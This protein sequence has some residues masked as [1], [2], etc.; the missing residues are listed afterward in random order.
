MAVAGAYDYTPL[1]GGGDIIPGTTAGIFERLGLENPTVP[2]FRLLGSENKGGT[3]VNESMNFAAIPGQSYRLVNNATGKV[4]G[5][6]SS[7]EEIS[8]LVAQSNALSKQLGKKADLSFEQSTGGAYSPIFKDQPNILFD[9]PMK[10]IAAGMLAAT[11]A[12]LLQPGGLGGV[13][14][15]GSD[16]AISN[17]VANAIN[18]AYTG[19]QAGAASALAPI[20]GAGAG[21]F[22][23]GAAGAG[24]LLSE[25]S[26]L[27]PGAL[28]SLPSNLASINA[29]TQASLAGAGLGGAT[30]GLAV[31]AFGNV[32]DKTGAIVATGGGGGS[33]L[34]AGLALGATGATAAVTSGGAGAGAGAAGATDAAINESLKNTIDTAYK[35]AQTGAASNLAGTYVPGAGAFVAPGAGATVG[36][37]GVLGTGLSLSELATLGSLGASAV[38]SLFGGG[39]GGTTATPYVSPFGAGPSFGG[40]DYRAN[41]NIADYEKYGF[42]P[43]ASFFRPEYSKLVSSGS[44][45]GYTPSV[46][47]SATTTT[48]TYNPLIGGGNGTISPTTTTTQSNATPIV[49]TP[50]VKQERPAGFTGVVAGQ[51]TGDTQVVDGNTWV[52]G[53]DS[54]G[55]QMKF[56]N[57]LL[58]TGNGGTN[59]SS[60]ANQPTT[61]GNQAYFAQNTANNPGWANTYH[62]FQQ[63]LIGAGITGDQKAAAERELFSAI[64]TQPFASPSAL[65]DYAR[66]IYNKYTGA[67]P[68]PTMATVTTGGTGGLLGILNSPSASSSTFAPNTNALLRALA[69]NYNP[70]QPLV[71]N[72]PY[73]PSNQ[74]KPIGNIPSGLEDV[75]RGLIG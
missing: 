1:Y 23:A 13:G 55:W 18:A 5:E 41:P 53:G 72:G 39:G 6:A 47:G 32:V 48:P 51:Q 44:N 25:G 67:A 50:T 10:L 57:G 63:G 16:A 34:P 38:G 37:G 9:T 59:V 31:D 11:G 14:A 54:V 8:A 42:G 29:A 68:S 49:T 70:D 21:A 36:A 66:G 35:N 65:V 4:V 12:G 40:M 61:V 60:L 58:S 2:V 74:P 22:S 30:S 15:A 64:E 52:W 26:S 33:L 7:P 56:P 62:G 27:A 45:M 17:S 75:V 28:S 43:E 73:I 24:G 20:Y 3:N 46:T 71:S 19:A 69:P